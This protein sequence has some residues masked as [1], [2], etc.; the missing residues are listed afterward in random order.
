VFCTKK[1][2]KWAVERQ[3]RDIEFD[4]LAEGCFETGFAA[5]EPE[6]KAK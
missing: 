2:N 3:M 1:L 4:A 6:W 5:D